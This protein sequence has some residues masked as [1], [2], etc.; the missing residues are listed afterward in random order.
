VSSNWSIRSRTA[1]TSDRVTELASALP[2]SP[3]SEDHTR[4]HIPDQCRQ[5]LHGAQ[6]VLAMQAISCSTPYTAPSHSATLV[7]G[8][9]E[10][11]VEHR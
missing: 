9:V 1:R 10:Q 11:H 7:V 2:N 5:R 3:S 6:L 8:V 4:Q